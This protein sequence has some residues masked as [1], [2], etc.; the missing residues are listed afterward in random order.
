MHCFSSH[1]STD[2]N[3]YVAVLADKFGDRAI[4]DAYTFEAGMRTID[5]ILKGLNITDLFVLLISDAAL[6][7]KWVKDEIT[8]SKRLLDAGQIK[9]FL[10]I[11]IDPAITYRDSRIPEWI[12]EAYNLRVIP[13]PNAAYRVINSAF[14]RLSINSNPKSLR[15]RRLFVGRNDQLKELE[16]R[17]DDYEKPLPAA[18]VAS[19]MREI[20][21]KK[22]LLHALRKA[23][24]I[25][26]H[27]LPISTT[28]HY[29]DGIDGFLSKLLDF[30]FSAK[31]DSLIDLSSISQTDKI[32]IIVELFTELGKQ[33]EILSIDDWRC[34]VQFGGQYADWFVSVCA[35]LPAN[36][37]YMCIASGSSPKASLYRN[38]NT[39]FHIRLPELDTTERL[40]LLVRYLRDVEG[41]QDLDLL[42]LSAFRNILNGYPEQ[43]IYAGESVMENGIDGALYRSA[44]IVDFARLK[45][46]VY[47][48]KYR[49]DKTTF[50]LLTFL[51][52]FEF[53]SI[54]LLAKLSVEM[55]EDL[56]PIVNEFIEAGICQSLGSLGEYIRLNDVI[57]DYVAR[58]SISI[59]PKFSEAIAQVSKDILVSSDNADDF[60]YSER[61]VS[62]RVALLEGREV[63][64]KMLIPAHFLKAISQNYKNKRYKNVIALCTR[65]LSRDNYEVYIRRQVLHFY[66][67][68]L[69]RRRDPIFLSEVQKIDGREHDYVLGFYYRISGRYKDTIPRF[70]SAMKEQRWEENSKRELVLIYNIIED[71]DSAFAL[72][73]K[74]YYDFPSNPI[75]VLAYF[76][77]LLNKYKSDQNSD[78]DFVSE[79]EATLLSISRV[80]SEKA[81]EVESGMKARYEYYVK[82]DE[83]TALQIVDDAID[84]FGGS[85]YP[86]LVKMEIGIALRSSEH[87][88]NALR[89][90][91]SKNFDHN[92]GATQRKK[93]ELFL[94][95]LGGQSSKAIGLVDRDLRYLNEVAR[96]RFKQRLSL[97]N[98]Q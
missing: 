11:I 59:P 18:I 4:Y 73:R 8:N 27:H 45:A 66:C 80:S 75:S 1:S 77:V 26:D 24:R 55:S 25:D 49:D 68:A 53:A 37:L 93:A 84:R 67:M 17:L 64:E 2:K 91:A 44:E 15:A 46:S 61:A 47:V 43:A 92:Q 28:L 63:P 22:Y 76:E 62:I 30:G 6:N 95:A 50:D 86:L 14:S 29:E 34:I 48:E 5:E 13:K 51:S 70:E 85:P 35:R 89:I 32:D 83:I 56:M 78:E 3:G 23:N 58:G 74:S 98:L 10:P 54:D 87:I 57:R 41:I 69:A 19:G 12:R 7:S 94:M 79:M 31:F 97:K 65:V 96:E 52:W 90:F 72:A 71:Y 81:Q 33:N 40:G 36:R 39:I 16:A 82:N 9:Q 42:K 20:G 60:D 88:S 38:N 21:R